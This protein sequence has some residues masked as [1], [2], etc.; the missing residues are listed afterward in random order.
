MWVTG[1]MKVGL[2]VPAMSL[3]CWTAERGISCIKWQ[4]LVL[5][6]PWEPR[7]TV[8]LSASLSLWTAVG[9][10]NTSALAR[11]WVTGWQGALPL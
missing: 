5:S 4:D 9:D 1:S 6:S 3:P 2:G 11:I 7:Q 8:A 10:E